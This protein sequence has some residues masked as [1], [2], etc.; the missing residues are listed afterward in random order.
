MNFLEECIKVFEIQSLIRKTIMFSRMIVQ[1]FYR[2]V[3]DGNLLN[4]K[5]RKVHQ[6]I[7]NHILSFEIQKKLIVVH[8]IK[9][10]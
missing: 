3:L 10:I 9:R 4:D 1:N 2:F 5:F 7:N 6:S 8:F